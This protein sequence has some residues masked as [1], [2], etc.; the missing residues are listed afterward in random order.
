MRIDG[1]VDEVRSALARQSGRGEHVADTA[2]VVGALGRVS[3]MTGA[4]DLLRAAPAVLAQLTGLGPLQGLLTD[5]AVTDV[6]VNGPREVWVDDGVAVAR[7]GLDLGDEAAVRALAVRLAA[8]AGRRLDETSPFVDARLPDGVRLHAVLP[9]ISPSGTLISLRVPSRRVFDLQELAAR[10]A[11]PPSWLP[12]LRAVVRGRLGF[13]VS[14]GTAT[15]KTTLLAGLLAAADP[16]DR[17]VVVEDTQELNPAL[18]HVV[19]LQGRHSNSEGAGTVTLAQLVS[20]ALRMRPDRLVV[21]EC[22]GAEVTD[23]LAALNTGHRGGCATVHANSAA[24]VPSRL[25]ALGLLAGAPRE[26]LARQMISGL[27][28]IIHLHRQG[29]VRRLST[30]AVL[31]GSEAGPQVYDAACWDGVGEPRSGP[32]WS[33]LTG[34]LNGSAGL[35]NGSD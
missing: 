4:G 12:L 34:L 10:G 22:R 16:S 27:D 6:L 26:A 25:E 24:D 19:S 33:V 30:I 14:G 3:P 29:G 17:V 35:L 28:V 2:A 7:T 21:G 20:Q 32:G 31:V 9:P 1:L 15:G 8:V 13:L 5:P 18:P 23:L 11:V